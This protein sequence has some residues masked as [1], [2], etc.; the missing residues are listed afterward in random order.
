[1]DFTNI[2]G[3]AF[4]KFMMMKTITSMTDIGL[5]DEYVSTFEPSGYLRYWIR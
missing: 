5:T 2:C 1:M 3:G 4:K